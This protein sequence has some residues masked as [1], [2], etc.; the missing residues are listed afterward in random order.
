M[1]PDLSELRPMKA[2]T[3]REIPDGDGWAGEPKFDGIR[4]LARVEE[5]AAHLVTR[6]GNERT[7]DFPQ[8]AAAL[9]DLAGGRTLLLDGEVVAMRGGQPARF[10][11]LQ[12]R[13]LDAHEGT[14]A[15][16]VFDLLYRDGRDLTPEPWR[17]RRAALE[18]LLEGED[19]P[20]LLLSPRRED[21]HALLAEARGQELE[22]IIAKRTDAPYRPGKRSR[23]WLKLK[24]ERTQEFVIGGWTPPQRSRPHLG[25]L[26]VGTYA[27][28]DLVYAGKVGTGFTHE[29]LER[30][31]GLLEKRERKTPPFA[32]TPK[33]KDAR[34]T[35]PDPVAQ[36]R[37]T[38]WAQDGRLRH[39]AFLGLREDKD[40][41]EVVREPESL[42]GD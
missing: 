12:R 26:L 40:A 21:L 25:A 31:R 5:G 23:A 19:S 8:V 4:M 1:M 42:A 35:R 41:R 36:I 37:F 28:E 14:N 16:A 29:D 13:A 15:F 17:E 33:V 18:A 39:P 34:W 20:H 22:G 2:T 24:I 3:A 27:G 32:G 9:E 38:E 7:I 11:T 10:Q 30:L 6:N